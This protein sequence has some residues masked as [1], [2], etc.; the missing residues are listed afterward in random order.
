MRQVFGV[1]GLVFGVFGFVGAVFA[2]VGYLTYRAGQDFAAQ[3]VNVMGKVERRW[4]STRDCKD[5]DSTVTRTCTDFNVGYGYMVDRRMWH[6]SAVT[7]YRIYA[8]LFEGA[9]VMV[10][11]LP[12]DP[13][14]NATSFDARGVDAAG[15]LGVAGLIFGGLGIIQGSNG[16]GEISRGAGGLFGHRFGNCRAA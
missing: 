13:G 7:D 9:P 5:Q 6:D 14:E 3:G 2:V 10:R 16:G 12:T 1:V 4:E 8:N 15:G 11:Y